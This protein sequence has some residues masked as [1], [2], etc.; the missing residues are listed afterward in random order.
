MTVSPGGEDTETVEQ[1]EEEDPEEDFIFVEE[2]KLQLVF[3]SHQDSFSNVMTGFPSNKH[4]VKSSVANR[5]SG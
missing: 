4:A 5:G 1:M 3:P 2:I